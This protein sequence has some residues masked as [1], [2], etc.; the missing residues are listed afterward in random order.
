MGEQSS[1]GRRFPVQAQQQLLRRQFQEGQSKLDEELISCTAGENL[2]LGIWKC[3][4][5]KFPPV[6]SPVM[7]ATGWRIVLTC[8]MAPLFVLLCTCVG[9]DGRTA[10]GVASCMFFSV[11]PTNSFRERVPGSTVDRLRARSSHLWTEALSDSLALSV[12]DI[13]RDSVCNRAVLWTDCEQGVAL[14]EQL[15]Y[16][17][18]RSLGCT[19]A[20]FQRSACG[21]A[22]REETL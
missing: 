18:T 7:Q 12:V 3:A 6:M 2:S 4:F 9:Y 17:P 14:V 10:A 8:V 16:T 22:A 20:F 13:G 19:Q 5:M 11:S 1:L 21:Q 15:P